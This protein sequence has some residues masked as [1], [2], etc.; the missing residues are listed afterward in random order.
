MGQPRA[1]ACCDSY[2]LERGV[3]EEDKE[4]QSTLLFSLGSGINAADGFNPWKGEVGR[5]G[6]YWGWVGWELK[7]WDLLEI[8][9]GW[10]GSV[11]GGIWA[12]NGPILGTLR[13]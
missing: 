10:A 6:G 12:E 8:E 7:G 9:M 11:Q 4:E 1:A 13:I 2:E 3:K 5:V